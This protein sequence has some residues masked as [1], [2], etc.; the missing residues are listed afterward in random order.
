MTDLMMDFD[1]GPAL[2]TDGPR[3]DPGGKVRLKLQPGVRGDAEY[4]ECGRYRHWL[5]RSWGE[6]DAPFILWVGM[7][8]STAEADVDDP[9]IRRELNFSREL[10]F[11]RYVKVNVMDYRATSPKILLTVEPRSA[12]NLPFILKVAGEASRVVAAWGALPKRLRHYADEVMEGLRD[13]EVYCMGWT[14]GGDPRHPL[15]LPKTAE[16]VLWD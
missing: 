5:V 7:N 16:C 15:Y 4:S 11:T 8:P 1:V 6:P 2:V 12:I 10:G 9:T 14:A 3:H 13:R